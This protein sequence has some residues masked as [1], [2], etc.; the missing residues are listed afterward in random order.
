[1]PSIVSNNNAKIS[2][3]TTKLDDGLHTLTIFS[4]DKVGHISINRYTFYVDNTPP[5]IEVKGIPT[6]TTNSNSYLVSGVLNISIDV[7]DATLKNFNIILPD[8]KVIENEHD[9]SIDT[10]MLSDGEHE[11][12]VYAYDNA[13]NS[14]E[15]I[16]RLMVDNTPPR[17]SIVSPA[18]MSKVSGVLEVRYEVSD[19]NLK[20]VAIAVDGNAKTVVDATGSYIIDTKGLIDGEHKIE[21]IAE[22]ML[23]HKSSAL[24][25]INA[26]NYAPVIEAEKEA[27]RVSAKEQGFQQGTLIGIAVGI[28]VGIG[29]MIGI[30]S[31]RSRANR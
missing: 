9:I 28:A 24:V 13:G 23:G 3:D 4:R 18:D 10:S 25:N 26:V 5:S 1:M 30:Y 7:R 15:S 21:V 20:S 22:D 27:I 29:A 14:S 31:I 16:L 11:L 8:G 6:I 17:V 2:I 12:R 19:Q